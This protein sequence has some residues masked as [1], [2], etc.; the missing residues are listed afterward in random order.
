MGLHRR[1]RP[2]LPGEQRVVDL[3]RARA[4]QD[5]SLHALRRDA[6]VDVPGS[7]WLTALR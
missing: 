5:R 4:K 6:D 1:N 7:D 2:V 3:E